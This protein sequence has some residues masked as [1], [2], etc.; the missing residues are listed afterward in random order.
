MHITNKISQYFYKFAS[1]QFPIP[2]QNFINNMYVKLLGL[3]MREFQSPESYK[4]LNA[5]FTRA[6]VIP[7]KIDNSLNSFISPTDSFVTQ[8]GDINNYLSLQIKGMSYNIKEL[9][10]SYIDTKKLDGGK[11]IN[12]YLSPKD[13]HRYHSI[14]NAKITKLIHVPGKLYPVNFTYLNKQESLFVENERVIVE[15]KTN[16]NGYYYMV[17]VGALNVGKMVF[18]FEPK[19][20]TN[21]G[22]GDISVYEYDNL[23]I[24]KG[25]LIGYFKMG[26]TVL[27][28]WEKDMVDLK[29]LIDTKIRFGDTIATLQSLQ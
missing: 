22:N 28:F 20:S 24:K 29:S 19:V 11:Y 12:F 7:R 4:T 17:F 21:I 1:T 13:Y 25:D 9:F 16:D 3:D 14:Y 5:L 26:S 15:F 10:T 2:I 6:L 23:Y 8:A 27:V 18:E